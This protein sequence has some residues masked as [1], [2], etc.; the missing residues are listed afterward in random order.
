M[1]SMGTPSLD[2]A[3][4]DDGQ[5]KDTRG[6]SEKDE[7]KVIV[8]DDDGETMALMFLL[9]QG[10]D[11]PE[12]DLD[13]WT[14]SEMKGIKIV[15][16]K[17]DMPTV[18]SLLAECLWVTVSTAG[19]YDLLRAFAVAVHFGQQH[20]ARYACSQIEEPKPPSQFSWETAQ[21][22]GFEAY[23]ILVTGES[24]CKPFSWKELSKRI[25]F[26]SN[27]CRTRIVIQ[28]ELIYYSCLA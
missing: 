26:V 10:T 15:A 14:D 7:G 21:E 24:K 27:Q 5:P 1:L 6:R 23:F 2:R 13:Y 19:S 9:L 8:I 4:D 11:R 20:L 25:L 3:D 17:Y 22:L 16:D 12:F 18:P 28:R